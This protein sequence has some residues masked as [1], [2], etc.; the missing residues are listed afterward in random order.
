MF[1]ILLEVLLD[2]VIELELDL[3]NLTNPEG[4]SLWD[5]EWAAAAAASAGESGAGKA[6]GEGIWP[7]CCCEP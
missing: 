7:G 1:L 4:R 2:A 6:G 5:S 3:R